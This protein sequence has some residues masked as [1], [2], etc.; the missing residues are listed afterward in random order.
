MRVV[1]AQIDWITEGKGTGAMIK[2]LKDNTAD[3]VIALTEGLVRDIVTTGSD[4]R[5]LGT[6]VVSDQP[7]PLHLAQQALQALL[8]WPGGPS[9]LPRG[10]DAA[11]GQLRRARD[12]LRCPYSCANTRPGGLSRYAGVSS[13]LGTF[14]GRESQ[15]K[16]WGDQ[17]RRRS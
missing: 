6:Y 8:W 12:N 15:Q 4:I 11:A 5:L 3:V 17:I 14:D 1:F 13:L 7:T 16:T 10:G 9:L 2:H